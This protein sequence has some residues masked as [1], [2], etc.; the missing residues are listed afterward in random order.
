[1]K[2]ILTITLISIITVMISS[3]C[4]DGSSVTPVEPQEVRDAKV[5]KEALYVG[6]HDNEKLSKA[7]KK[8]AKKTGWKITEFKS[9]EV[10]AEKTEAEDTIS[11]SV[12]FSHGYVEFSNNDDTSD[13]RDAIKEELSSNTATH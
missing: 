11:S 13:L 7:I 2:K 12:C 4:K 3:G 5:S 1:M 6:V 10:L 9:N 8:A